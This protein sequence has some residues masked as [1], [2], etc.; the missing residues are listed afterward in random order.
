MVNNNYKGARMKSESLE[1]RV[2][3]LEDLEEIKKLHQKYIDLMDNLK[4]LEVLDLF[5]DDAEVEVR[6]S[7]VR[8]GRKEFSQIYLGILAKKRKVRDC[9]H[10]AVQPDIVVD[11][12]HAEGT[13]LIY[14]LFSEPKVEWVQGINAVEYRKLNGQWKI[15]DLKFTRSLASRP[16]LYP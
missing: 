3:A 8:K 15:S 4:Y 13:W 9:A 12:D 14:M 10:L 2:K 16:D 5:T 6:D 7:G 11:G 1:E